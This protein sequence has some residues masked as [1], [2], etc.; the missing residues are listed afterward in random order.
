MD[1]TGA[2]LRGSDLDRSNLLG[3]A[4]TGANMSRADLTGADL[5]RAD[6]TGADLT[7]AVL[8]GA[9][10]TGAVLT[11]AVLTGAVLTGA[12][13]LDDAKL[14]GSRPILQIGA[15][16]SCADHSGCF[17]GYVTDRGLYLRAGC[18]MGTVAEFRARL[19]TT[20]VCTDHER[21]YLAA[22]S[23]METHFEIW[24]E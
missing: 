7:G 1:L 14:I 15:I 8:T 22:L 24:K 18:Y 5:T 2:N 10:L 21:E 16:G 12:T 9:V 23:M 4:L 3:A 13:I 19:S 20:H 6:L 17:T 11:G